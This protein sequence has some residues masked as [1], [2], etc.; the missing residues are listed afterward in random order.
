M[1][2]NVFSCPENYSSAVTTSDQ[3]EPWHRAAVGGAWEELGRLQFELLVNEGLQPHHQFLDVGCGSLRGGVHFIRY[4]DPDHYVGMDVD[5]ELILAGREELAMA[6][7]VDRRPTLVTRGDFE[8]REIG[9]QFDF[10]LAQSVFTHLPFNNIVRCVAGVGRVLRPGGQFLATF[11]ANRESR[12][13]TDPISLTAND[14]AETIKLDEDP[15]FYSPELFEWLCEGSDLA[16]EY[17]GDWGHPRHQH[18]LIF[19]KVR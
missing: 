5:A 15:Y 14:W 8:F 6:G 3:A 12:L 4:L 2:I 13:R 10:A 9:R 18:L 17:R 7:L 11:F 16:C 1:A 19:T